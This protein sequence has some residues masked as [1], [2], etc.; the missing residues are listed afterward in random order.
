MF[1]RKI[2]VLYFIRKNTVGLREKFHICFLLER[3]QYICRE[4]SKYVFF[5]Q[6]TKDLKKE[7]ID[8]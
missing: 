5:E 4:N 1:E 2:P 8:S 3:K 6:K 7:T